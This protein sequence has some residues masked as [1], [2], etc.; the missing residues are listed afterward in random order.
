MARPDGRK[1]RRGGDMAM[2]IGG[3]R[4]LPPL[5]PAP[6]GPHARA[7]GVAP[8]R[9]EWIA[10][11]STPSAR[12][13]APPPPMPMPMPLAGEA[14][15]PMRGRRAPLGAQPAEDIHPGSPS[16][17]HPYRSPASQ[18]GGGEWHR[19]DRRRTQLEA[20]SPVRSRCSRAW[21]RHSA[22]AITKNRGCQRSDLHWDRAAT[23]HRGGRSVHRLLGRDTGRYQRVIR[24]GCVDRGC[25]RAEPGTMRTRAE[26]YS[27]GDGITWQFRSA[28]TSTSAQRCHLRPRPGSSS[29][30]TGITQLPDDILIKI[31]ALVAKHAEPADWVSMIQALRYPDALPRCRRFCALAT[32]RLVLKHGTGSM[33]RIAA[34]AW[35]CS[36]ERYL[37]EL[38]DAENG[39]AAYVLGMVSL[40]S[41][42]A[43]RDIS[44]QER[45]LLTGTLAA[46]DRFTFIVKRSDRRA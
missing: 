24:Q 41:H 4:V 12:R 37:K 33:C 45:H 23:P 3:G 10:D 26:D 17:H 31:L 28:L 9:K 30:G 44:A 7:P 39:N 40:R 35:D 15:P 46:V 14:R 29:R 16:A 6:R 18:V 5:P 25:G 34:S 2:W 8:R 11:A 13:L 36:A 1:T 38:C 20:Q 43:T 21:P 22:P 27:S 19:A 42:H 32:H